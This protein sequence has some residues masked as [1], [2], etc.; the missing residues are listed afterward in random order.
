MALMTAD[1]RKR[2]GPLGLF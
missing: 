2:D 1:N